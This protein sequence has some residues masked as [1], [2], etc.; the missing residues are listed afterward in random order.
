MRKFNLSLNFI[1]TLLL[2][3]GCS[4]QDSQLED[5]VNLKNGHKHLVPFK[6][7]YSV[8]SE[9]ATPGPTID[10]IV[11]GSGLANHLGRSDVIVNETITTLQLPWS[12]TA[13]VVITAANGDELHFNYSSEIDP[14]ALPPAGNG[15]LIIAGDCIVT[16]G[17]G[18]FENATGT[19]V[20][21]GVFNVITSTGTAHFTGTIRY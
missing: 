14:S 8:W 12:A 5:D 6:A 4:I 17:T 10:L 11:F 18:R 20:Y 7:T 3:I 19:F 21:N 9:P 1:L 15:D 13:S 2:I 16:G